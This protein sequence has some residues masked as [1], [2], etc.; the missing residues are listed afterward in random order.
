MITKSGYG[1][2]FVHRLGHS[3]GHEVH[4]NGVN[5]D[6]WETHDTRTMIQGIGVTIEPGVYLPQFGVRLEMD[7]YMGVDGPEIT[8]DRQD[9]IVRVETA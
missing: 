5:L 8:G 3:L 1:E 2:H 9:E 7:V 4:S 6:D